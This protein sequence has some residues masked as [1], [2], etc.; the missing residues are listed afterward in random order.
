MDRLDLNRPHPAFEGLYFKLKPF[1][2]FFVITAWTTKASPL[3]HYVPF[4]K[5]LF[6]ILFCGHSV[7]FRFVGFSLF[8]RDSYDPILVMCRGIDRIEFQVF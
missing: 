7:E 5:L 3:C 2:T 6:S 4:Q 1:M 8:L